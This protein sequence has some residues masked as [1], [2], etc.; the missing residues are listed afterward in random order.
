M[1]SKTFILMV[2]ISLYAFSGWTAEESV[3]TWTDA[4]GV[5]T[6]TN[7]KPEDQR[8][9]KSV[10]RYQV[11]KGAD[12]KKL[13]V[14]KAAETDR[15]NESTEPEKRSDLEKAQKEA[16]RARLAAQEA[17]EKADA[18]KEKVGLKKKRLRKNR[19]RIKK[20]DEQ[21]KLAEKQADIAAEKARS[22]EK[23]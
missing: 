20:L 7:R 3:Y 13:P 21:A 2:F 6:I 22:L 15:I 1:K 4:K 9:A 10:D 16:E 17:R 23:R 18:F 11:P 12:I 5:L 14:P 8:K 19:S